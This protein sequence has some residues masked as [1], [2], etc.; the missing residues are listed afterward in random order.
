MK[1]AQKNR[2]TP[3]IARLVI[4]SLVFA[5]VLLAWH[6]GYLQT[7]ELGAYDDWIRLRPT[8]SAG[9]PRIALITITENDIQRLGQWPLSDETLARSLERLLGYQPRAIGIDIYRDIP[10]PPGREALDRVLSRHPNIIAT[11]QFGD[12]KEAGVAPPPVLVDTQQ[13]GFNDI[14]VD[15]DET[16]RRGLLFLDQGESTAYSFALRLA[17]RYLEKPGVSPQPDPVHPEH[18]RLGRTTLRPFEANDGG[19]VNADARGYQFLLD[20]RETPAAMA[21]YT[22]TQLLAGEIDP[23]ALKDKIV[24]VGVTAQSVKDFFHTPQSGWFGENRDTHGV[25]LHALITDQLLRS[26][27][28]GHTPIATLS[29]AWEA[30]WILC[31]SLLGAWLGYRRSSARYLL[32]LAGGLLSLGSLVYLMFLGGRW[33]PLAGPALAWLL[34]SSIVIAYLLKQESQQRAHLMHLFARH[35][36]PEIAEE[37]WRQRD[38]FLS[39]NRPRPTKMTAT[40]MFSDV[41]GFTQLSEQLEPQV[42]MAWLN[43]YLEAITPV[44]SAHQGVV[45]RFIGDAILAAFGVPLARGSETQ[46]QQDALNAVE[47]ALAMERKMLELNHRWRDRGLPAVGTRIGITTGPVV[48]GSIGDS[49]RLEYSIHG[50]TVNTAARLESFDKDSFTPDFLS[51]PSRIL[52]GESTLRYVEHRFVTEPYGQSL[53]R[54]KARSVGVFRVL[55]LRGCEFFDITGKRPQMNGAAGETIGGGISP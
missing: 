15:P 20:F 9:Q 19:Y 7:I 38:Q 8:L 6:G 13:V 1:V 25:E 47:C 16:V 2:D 34:S 40:V 51:R 21:H 39:G 53:L 31:W 29:D 12:K 24:L 10:V 4:A 45:I 49:A 50:D 18:L 30:L 22:L 55:G 46:V 11:M 54:G 41:F 3:L 36:S 43:E 48:A 35:I 33:L 17:L 27:L 37:I 23:A 52:I 5:G 28:D 14:L 44:I 42:L 32:G 26:A